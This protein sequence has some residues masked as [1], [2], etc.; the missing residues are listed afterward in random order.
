MKL[1]LLVL[2]LLLLLTFKSNSREDM[3]NIVLLF[4]F[5]VCLEIL[6]TLSARACPGTLTSLFQLASKNVLQSLKAQSLTTAQKHVVKE[7]VKE[8]VKKQL[9]GNFSADY[10]ARYNNN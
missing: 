1:V 10:V 6:K 8:E 7:A 5:H 3:G 9:A 2:L 4:G